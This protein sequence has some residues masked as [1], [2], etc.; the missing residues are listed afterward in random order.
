M[1]RAKETIINILINLYTLDAVYALMWRVRVCP[2]KDAPQEPPFEFD[3]RKF[4][5]RLD[6]L[7]SDKS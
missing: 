3:S 2:E 1:K 5:P 6:P 7:V 4:M